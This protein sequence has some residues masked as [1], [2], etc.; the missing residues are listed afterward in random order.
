MLQSRRQDLEAQIRGLREEL[1]KGRGRLQATHE[2]LLLLR[3]ERR[4]HGLEVTGRAGVGGR[5]RLRA[6][7]T[8]SG[9]PGR[10]P[11]SWVTGSPSS[12]ARRAK[13]LAQGQVGA[14]ERLSLAGGSRMH[15]RPATGGQG[16][17]RGESSPSEV[18]GTWTRSG[19][20]NRGKKMEGGSMP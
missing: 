7:I 6:W 18:M 4:E 10:R 15:Q 1:E 9:P 14:T 8:A 5:V 16:W 11:Q 12:Q 17:G 20:E 2:E 19:C 3:R 13:A